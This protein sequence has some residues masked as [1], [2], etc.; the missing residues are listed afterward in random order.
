MISRSRV[1]RAT[2]GGPEDSDTAPLA[3]WGR[4]STESHWFLGA[5]L[6]PDGEGRALPEQAR[7]SGNTDYH[8]GPARSRRT[9][10]TEAESP[11]PG[12]SARAARHF[13]RSTSHGNGLGSLSAS[14]PT[15]KPSLSGTQ[16]PP[17]LGSCVPR[18]DLGLEGRGHAPPTSSRCLQFRSWI[19]FGSNCALPSEK[20][21][22]S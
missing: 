7:T 16:L 22:C 11:R 21:T 10:G 8:P 4:A 3:G 19:Y 15:P 2:P 5:G 14:A 13:D 18:D 20:L 6:G 12:Y 1:A 17:S 9:S